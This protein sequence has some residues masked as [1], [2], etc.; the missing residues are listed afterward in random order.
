MA[1]KASEEEMAGNV[2]SLFSRHPASESA[3][4]TTEAARTSD[5]L[6]NIGFFGDP[7]H[8]FNSM[9]A[10]CKDLAAQQETR[11]ASLFKMRALSP[12]SQ[13]DNATYETTTPTLK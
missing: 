1:Y 2:V 10:K 4:K 5:A 7:Q 13:E 11:D 6:L 8:D 9:N 3:N 12:T